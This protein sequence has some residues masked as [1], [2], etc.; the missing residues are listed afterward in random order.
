LLAK[1]R[2]L[3][4]PALLLALFVSGGCGIGGRNTEMCSARP[5]RHRDSALV[6]LHAAV[7]AVYFFAWRP[8]VLGYTHVEIPPIG[9]SMAIQIS[10][11]LANWPTVLGWMFFP[12]HSST[13]DVVRVVSTLTDPRAILGAALVVASGIAWGLWLRRGR[14][15]TALAIAWIWI[16]Y[17]PTA[18]LIPMLHANG[19]RY[20]FL[21]VFGAS[22]LFAELCT[23]LARRVS[24]VAG[25]IAA[26]VVLAFLAQRTSA[27]IPEWSSNRSLFA[28]EIARDPAFREAYFIL[29]TELQRTGQL[30]QAATLL[31]SVLAEGP[32]FA[33][34]ASYL[35]PLSTHELLCG[36]ELERQQYAAILELERQLASRQPA[37]VRAPTLRACIGQAHDALGHTR[38][39]L[40]HYLGVSNELKNTAPP[41]LYV[42]IARNHLRLGDAAAAHPGVARARAAGGTDSSL[43]P[44]L[45]QLERLLRHDEAARGVG[46]R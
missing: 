19:E 24:P 38:I 3:V 41:V 35:N 30:D 26:L 44:Q 34:T 36:V 9:G 16:A 33:G 32:P 31:R 6:A 23:L 43:L 28:S 46:P 20:V 18:G 37:L 42:M 2:A 25:V 27:R 45:Q 11:A 7:V 4:E 17:L 14:G 39:A 29:G 15:L 21:S 5:D 22:L 8:V 13:S 12:L 10:S 1:E 40:G